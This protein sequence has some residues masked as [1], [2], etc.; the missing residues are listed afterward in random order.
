MNKLAQCAARVLLTGSVALAIGSA[1]PVA[2]ASTA[3][4]KVVLPGASWSV[5]MTTK[6]S[7][8]VVGDHAKLVAPNGHSL[9]LTVDG[10]ETS[11]APG[12]Y[13]GN[14]VLTVTR[15][16]VVPFQEMQPYRFRAALT[17]DAGHVSKEQSVTA[18]L[19]EGTVNDRS[20][21]DVSIVSKGEKF[22]GIV[23]GGNSSYTINNPRIDLTGNGTNDFAGQAAA[24]MSRGNARVT[25]NHAK[26]LT[27]GVVRT[28]VFVGGDSTMT[29]NDSSIEVHDGTLPSDYQFSIQPGKMME[30]PYGLG[31]TGNVRATNLVDRG[32]V[33]YNNS[34]IKAQGWGALSSDGEGPTR[35]F[36]T[37]CLIE[38]VE[39]GYGAY[40][41]GDAHD[42]FAH[43]TFNVVDYGLIIG[44]NGSG[45]FTD[46]SVVN[47]KKIG[48][49]MHQ[50]T[51]GSVLTIERKS[52]INSRLSAIQIKGRGA[53]VIIDDAQLH[54]GNG[55][56]VQ[57]MDNDD[58]II[59]A[60]AAAA[61]PPGEP[62]SGG[63]P[64]GLPGAGG[65]AFSPDV[66]VALR[67]AKLSG[68][69]LHAMTTGGKLNVVLQHTQLA[70]AISTAKAEPASGQAP[71]RESFHSVGE[72][73]NILSAGGAQGGLTL[74]LDGTSSWTVARTSYLNALTLA[75]GS[76]I[77]APQGARV[78]LFVDGVARPLG[79]GS[80]TGHIELR[81]SRGA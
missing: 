32:T 12:R 37:N 80:Y 66:N 73:A 72:V 60:M 44:G 29:V 35:M 56:L 30:V 74:M 24:I 50:G 64:V 11:I 5:N 43:T 3:A 4:T 9:T 21:D 67:N 75:P 28:G 14:V 65:E 81:V 70:G 13:R 10:V 6:L 23:V 17:V 45:T 61:P 69:L 20:A 59:K 55:V 41:N 7:N 58:P 79:A 46:A 63:G 54:P 42:H 36:V 51:G 8:L 22:N 78:E 15:D 48:V 52:E 18:A 31:F 76:R 40:S 33:Y 39:S 25:V 34:H 57:T 62:P 71:T 26:I 16:I 47:S 49:M 53:D 68:D 27:H 38:T 19:R 77:D 1:V 2:T